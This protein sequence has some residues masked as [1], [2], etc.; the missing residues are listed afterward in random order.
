M[1]KEDVISG[2]VRAQEDFTIE[3]KEIEFK[4]VPLL[5]TKSKLKP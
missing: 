3:Y 5:I 4:G 1:E 2:I